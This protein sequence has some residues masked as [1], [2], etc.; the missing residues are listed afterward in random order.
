MSII[1]VLSSRSLGQSNPVINPG[2]VVAPSQPQGHYVVQLVKILPFFVGLMLLLAGIMQPNVLSSVYFLI[3]IIL[4]VCWAFHLLEHVMK[5]TSFILIKII[6][7]VYAGL[8]V[9]VLYM[10]QFPFFQE[11]LEPDSFLPR[12]VPLFDCNVSAVKHQLHQLF[13]T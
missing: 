2:V 1:A 4:G 13:L 11:I 3:F 7:T 10:Y 5:N 8:H 12:F 6:L 9:L